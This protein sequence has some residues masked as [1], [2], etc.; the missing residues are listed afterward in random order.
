MLGLWVGE[1]KKE[2]PKKVNLDTVLANIDKLGD[3][4][5]ARFGYKDDPVGHIETINSDFDGF[6]NLEGSH[7]VHKLEIMMDPKS[8]QLRMDKMKEDLLQDLYTE[9]QLIKFYDVR[10]DEINFKKEQEAKQ[11]LS[12]IRSGTKSSYR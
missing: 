10:K 5:T 12:S 4:I 3:E 7:L 11:T 8:V 1:K 2:Q 9:D 6:D